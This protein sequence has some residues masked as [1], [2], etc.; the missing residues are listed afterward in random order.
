MVFDIVDI[1][2]KGFLIGVLVSAPMG[3]IGLLCVQRTLKKGLWHGFFSG[4][5]AALSDVFYAGIISLGVGFI[6]N[7]ITVNQYTLHIIGSIMLLIFGVYVLRSNPFKWLHEPKENSNS[8]SQD[9]V[10]A[11]FLT[12][13]NPVIIFLYLLF[14]ARLNFIS[15]EEKLFS[16]LLGLASILVG[17]LSWWLLIT[18][19]VDKLR[20][21]MNLKGLWIMNKI[22]GS[23]IIALSVF[24]LISLILPNPSLTSSTDF[25]L[26][27]TRHLSLV[28]I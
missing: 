3:P 15:S 28:T 9:I 27:V 8:Y 23:V 19:F 7:F 12:L 20:R 13:S 1:I 25:L 14:F 18:F 16:I 10:S 6:I 21:R 24:L 11:F 5:G 17:A 2:Y 22:V 4:V 26:P